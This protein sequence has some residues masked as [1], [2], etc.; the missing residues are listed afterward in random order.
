MSAP[1]QYRYREF[2]MKLHVILALAVTVGLSGAFGLA[3][4]DAQPA[5]TT[6]DAHPAAA[7][8]AAG[9]D[10]PGLLAAL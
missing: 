10:F 7:K 6:I 2:A 9:F 4:A 1:R 8:K 3:P 5:A